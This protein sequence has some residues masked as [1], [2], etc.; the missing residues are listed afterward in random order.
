MSQGP[1]SFRKKFHV[2][3]KEDQLSELLFIQM[4]VYPMIIKHGVKDN[5]S[6]KMFTIYQ[7]K[8]QAN[9]YNTHSI[10][11]NND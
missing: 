11:C 2:Q 7:V 1:Y 10:F 5:I 9:K 6:W 3:E 8:E 4:M